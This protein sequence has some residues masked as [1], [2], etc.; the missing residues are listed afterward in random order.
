MKLHTL[1]LK[2]ISFRK[3]NVILLILASAAAIAAFVGTHASMKSYDKRTDEIIIQREAETREAM[4]KL[5]DDYRI[6]MKRLGYN[7][8]ILHKDE[9]ISRLKIKGYPSLFMPEEAAE[10]VG[11]SGTKRLNHLLP[12]LQTSL[13]W[14]EQRRNIIVSGIRHQ[15]P[16]SAKKVHLD[17][18]GG[19]RSP[20]TPPLL[21]NTANLGYTIAMETSLSKGSVFTLKG[22]RFTVDTIYPQRGNNDDL[23]VWLPLDRVQ[24][25]IGKEGKI[26][27]IFALQCVCQGTE[28][29]MLSIRKDVAS[30]LPYAQVIEF[31]SIAAVR[32]EAR[33]RASDAHKSA[34][35]SELKNRGALRDARQQLFSVAVPSIIVIALVLM[36]ILS[37]LN[38]RERRLEI[39]ILKALGLR[40]GQ[41]IYLFLLRAILIGLIGGFTGYCIGLVAGVFAGQPSS[42][43]AGLL[44]VFRGSTFLAVLLLTPFVSLVTSWIPTL[45]AAKKDPATI[46]REG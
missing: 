24:K 18:Q 14:P 3:I 17:E 22:E 2:E 15:I 33:K 44:S 13:Y 9:N 16:V 46:L 39:A 45:I 37:L 35:E 11:K 12:F 41:I 40:S 4:I 7:A 42:L 5:E 23:I 43:G 6:I 21:K 8:L 36:T 28:D 10:K 38:V 25:W 26:N 20:I 32:Q 1:V 19:Y 27:G 31:A 34:I 29:L 30:V